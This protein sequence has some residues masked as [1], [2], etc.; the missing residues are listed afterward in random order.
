MQNGL[1]SGL[2][3]YRAFGRVWSQE[4]RR[5]GTRK[6]PVKIC[7]LT[8]RS[9]QWRQF[10]AFRGTRINLR[11]CHDQVAR[12]AAAKLL[13]ALP[14]EPEYAKRG[15]VVQRV[16]LDQVMPLRVVQRREREQEKRSVRHDGQ[17]AAPRRQ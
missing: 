15:S 14:G 11:V 10:G 1:A 2:L 17:M 12:F 3:K 9:W 4:D 8:A 7:C 16:V 6:Q 5:L 13:L